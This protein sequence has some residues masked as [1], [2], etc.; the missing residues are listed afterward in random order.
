VF[1]VYNIVTWRLK[2]IIWPSARQ[3]F[4]EHISVAT[5]NRPLLD[6]GLVNTHCP[7]TDTQI[8][9][10]E[11]IKC[12]FSLRSAPGLK[13]IRNW[14]K[15][16]GLDWIQWFERKWFLRTSLCGE[17]ACTPRWRTSQ[18]LDS[19]NTGHRRCI[20]ELLLS[21]HHE[22]IPRSRHRNTSTQST[23]WHWDSCRVHTGWSRGKLWVDHYCE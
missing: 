18:C 17:L 7:A 3:R 6:N 21:C 23:Q 11:L 16:P 15:T 10:D 4:H 2:A 20:A 19:R 14:F 1:A 12:V 13:R 9:T 22:Q 8:T 5:R